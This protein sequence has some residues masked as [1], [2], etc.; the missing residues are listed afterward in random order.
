MF[1][2]CPNLK[3]KSVSR[4]LWVYW[5]IPVHCKQDELLTQMIG[6]FLKPIKWRKKHN[7]NNNNK[8]NTDLTLYTLIAKSKSLLALKVNP[9]L[10]QD[11]P[12][13]NVFLVYIH[14]VPNRQVLGGN[15]DIVILKLRTNRSLNGK[16]INISTQPCVDNKVFVNF[17]ISLFSNWPCFAIEG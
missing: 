2:L 1:F 3:L 17:M 4:F 15:I 12:K 5:Y 9:K 13:Q 10:H 6:I 8:Q 7:N 11:L 16:N 14:N